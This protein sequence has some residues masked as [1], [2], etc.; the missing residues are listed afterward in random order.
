MGDLEFQRIAWMKILNILPVAFALMLVSCAG[1][2]ESSDKEAKAEFETRN[3]V[4]VSE[5]TKDWKYAWV[6]VGDSYT[7]YFKFS[8]SCPMA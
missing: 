4:V 7:E 8:T 2:G 3:Q 6:Q 5:H 1:S